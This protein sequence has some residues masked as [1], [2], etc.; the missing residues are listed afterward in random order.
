MQL[1]G[2]GTRTEASL[3]LYNNLGQL[4]TTRGIRL[5]PGQ[6]NQV[7]ISTTGLAAGVYI[8]RLTG[9][10]LNAVRRVVIE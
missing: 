1:N 9:P 6:N 10:S 4:L 2:P 8:L 5:M 7:E 3:G